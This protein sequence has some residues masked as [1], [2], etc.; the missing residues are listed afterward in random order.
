[1]KNENADLVDLNVKM[2]NDLDLI[3][4]NI[5][6]I[7]DDNAEVLFLII[8]SYLMNFL[9]LQFKMNKLKMSLPENQESMT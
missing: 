3:K 6:I 2:S 8:Q 1:M 5:D 9:I 4:R 7:N